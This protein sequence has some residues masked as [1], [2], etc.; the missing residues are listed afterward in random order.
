VITN[1]DINKILDVLVFN[2]DSTLDRKTSIVKIKELLGGKR[3]IKIGKKE[4][5]CKNHKGAKFLPLHEFHYVG[6]SS[7]C[8]KCTVIKN[9]ENR[10]KRERKEFL[11]DEINDEWGNI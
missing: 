1:K 7:Y 4:C 6:Y 2:Q 9:Y 11:E 10:K 8:K 5:T 3:D